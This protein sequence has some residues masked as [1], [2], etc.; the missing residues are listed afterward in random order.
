MTEQTPTDRPPGDDRAPPE[1]DE[2]AT[3]AH[4]NAPVRQSTAKSY[5]QRIDRVLRHLLDRLDCDPG[6]AELADVACLSPYHFHRVFQ[7]MTGE[8]V[9]ALVRRLRLERAAW[10]LRT[11]DQSVTVAALDAGFASPEAFSRAFRTACGLSPRAYRDAWP[12]P[13]FAPWNARIAYEPASDSITF[14]P[15][16]GEP[17]MDVTITELPERRVAALRHIGPYIEV[18]DTFM[19]LVDWAARAGQL[20]PGKPCIGLS[21]DNPETTDVAALRYDACVEVA[22]GVV[23]PEGFRIETLPAARYAMTRVTGPY[24]QL[25]GAY[26][27]LFGVWLP[28]SGAEPADLPCLELYWNS[29]IDT[30]ESDLIT[31]IG[32][33]L[34]A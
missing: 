25:H 18:G 1:R 6:L 21:Y 30:P 7:A 11:H 14:T 34:K 12:P 17:A 33:P 13:G 4:K 3:S 2:P 20:A 24:H 10:R 9:A 16:G 8:T 22:D 26:Q 23:P 32:I 5:R 27:K 19:Q 29:I 31:D 15:I 28:A